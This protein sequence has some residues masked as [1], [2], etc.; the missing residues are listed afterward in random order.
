MF[1]F[2]QVRRSRSTGS[3]KTVFVIFY[4]YKGETDNDFLDDNTVYSS[5][6]VDTKSEENENDDKFSFNVFENI[7]DILKTNL[8][9]AAKN[10]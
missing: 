6:S 3:D 2:L 7:S 5:D 10:I 1:I 4:H 8:S 9:L